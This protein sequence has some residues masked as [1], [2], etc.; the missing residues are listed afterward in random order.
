LLRRPAARC[1]SPTRRC[2]RCHE[3]SPAGIEI[4][5]KL[6]DELALHVEIAVSQNTGSNLLRVYR[7]TCL[8]PGTPLSKIHL[9]ETYFVFE[10]MLST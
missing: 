3:L 1:I 9:G 7:P 6:L 8:T 2:S 5:P 10:C 4:L